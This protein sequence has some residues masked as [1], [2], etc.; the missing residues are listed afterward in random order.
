MADIF[1]VERVHVLFR[2]DMLHDER[3]VQ[4]LRQRRLH[5]NAVDLRVCV[6]LFDKRQKLLLRG[7]FRQDVFLGVNAG[8]GAGLAFVTHVDFRRGVFADKHDRHAGLNALL[9]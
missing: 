2:V 3:F 7:V 8:L 6:Q 4:V 9:F 1:G 5:Q